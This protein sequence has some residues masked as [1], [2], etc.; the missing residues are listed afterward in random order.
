MSDKDRKEL[1][2]DL[3]RIYAAA[4]EEEGHEQLPEV[5]EKW[6]KKYPVAELRKIMYT[7]NAIESLNSIYRRINKSR[8]VFP[9]DQALLKSICLATLKVT[10][11]WTIR[12]SR[13]TS[14]SGNG[15][16]TRNNGQ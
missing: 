3:K 15:S 9:S 6:E 10:S 14:S 5:S 13:Q 4:N 1:A 16:S 2:K 11:K 7:T 12:Y 8:T